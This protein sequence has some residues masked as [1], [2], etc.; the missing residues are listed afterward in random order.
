V[1]KDKMKYWRGGVWGNPNKASKEKGE[2]AVKL[3]VKKIVD[4]ID[5]LE[6]IST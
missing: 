5:M 4:I 2:K 3:I 6:K 1:V